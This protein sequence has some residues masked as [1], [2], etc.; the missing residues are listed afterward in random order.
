MSKAVTQA[1]WLIFLAL[2]LI[3]ALAPFEWMVVASLKPADE[4]LIR[5]NPWWPDTPHWANYTNLL[6]SHTFQRWLANSAVVMISTLAISLVGAS[7]PDTRW[8]TWTCP[9]AGASSSRSSPPTCFRR[10]SFSYLL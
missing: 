1:P 3:F 10:G 7:S 5:G 6:A 2:L 4:Q 9:T 8:P